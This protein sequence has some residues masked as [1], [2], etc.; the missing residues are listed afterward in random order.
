MHKNNT[1]RATEASIYPIKMIVL[2]RTL[3]VLA[4]LA[5]L[6]LFVEVVLRTTKPVHDKSNEVM[7]RSLRTLQS[8]GEVDRFVLIN[9]VTD[10]PM[11]DL[12]NGTVINVATQNTSNFT[13][14]ATILNNSGTVGSIK[15]GYNARPAF[16]IDAGPLFAL[17]GDGNPL[18]NFFTCSHLTATTAAEELHTVSA[19]PYS[20]TKANGTKG[21]TK[22]ISFRIVNIPPTLAPTI[23]PTKRPSEQPSMGLSIEP[24]TVP[25]IKPSN[26]PSMILSPRPSPM[27]V[28]NVPQV[29]VGCVFRL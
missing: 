22:A 8:L 18:G 23:S 21:T 5:T 2:T 4:L 3:F 29:R 25:S 15:F 6:S 16:R 14:Q 1:K 9:A 17:C 26:E 20:G 7:N 28:C 19:T 12:V 11:F 24:S 27:P 13:I 10:L